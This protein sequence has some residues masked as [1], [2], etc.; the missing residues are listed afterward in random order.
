VA[1]IV[2]LVAQLFGYF[3][4]RIGV[5]S[6]ESQKIFALNEIH[7]AGINGFGSQLV[8]L[9]RNGGAQAEHFAR[10]SDLEYQG[11]AIGRTDGELDS[12]FAQNEDASRRLAF[13]KQDRTL[14]IRRGI[15]DAFKGLQ[16]SRVEVTEEPV[17][18]KL[19]SQAA[20]ND[21]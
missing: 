4:T 15:L 10:L 14:R 2:V 11:F 5:L 16:G 7:L 8:R 6:Q 1:G 13:H 18:P 9:T 19:A 20:F 3:E 12:S 17:G 21:V